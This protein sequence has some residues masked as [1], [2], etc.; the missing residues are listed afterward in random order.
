MSFKGS[1]TRQAPSLVTA[2]E[3]SVIFLSRDFHFV[4]IFLIK[5]FYTFFLVFPK[6]KLRIK[7]SL[8]ETQ[9]AIESGT[10]YSHTKNL[11]LEIFLVNGESIRFQVFALSFA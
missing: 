3:G 11:F 10:T 7:N 5:N 8:P 1:D 2:P 4:I 9:D 6:D